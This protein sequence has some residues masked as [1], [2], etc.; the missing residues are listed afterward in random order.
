[1]GGEDEIELLFLL[2]LSFIGLGLSMSDA[3]LSWCCCTVAA[4]SVGVAVAARSVGN[5]G[6][7]SVGNVGGV[8]ARSV[9]MQVLL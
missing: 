1:M 8:A 6:G 2:Y 4:R 3:C 5:V 7:R 9:I